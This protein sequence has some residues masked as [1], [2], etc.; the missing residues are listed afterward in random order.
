MLL[1]LW[2][3]PENEKLHNWLGKGKISLS[4][5]LEMLTRIFEQTFFSHSAWLSRVNERRK[6]TVNDPRA[7]LIGLW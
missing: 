5:P 4:R 3:P 6:S 7:T 2:L 1:W